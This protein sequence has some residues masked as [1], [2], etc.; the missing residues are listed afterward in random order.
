MFSVVAL[1]CGS[2]SLSAQ[3]P[4]DTLAVEVSPVDTLAVE[5]A[6]VDT[7]VIEVVPVDSLSNEVSP[8]DTLATES[9]S[10]DTPAV[11]TPQDDTLAVEAP[12]VDTLAVEVQPADTLAASEWTR[13]LTLKTNIAGW[14]LLMTNLAV[15]IDII[16]NL[17]FNLPVYYSGWD[18]GKNT[19]KFRTLTI[20]PEFRYYIPKAKGFYCGI[21][22]GLAHFNFALD[23]DWRYQNHKGE[24]LVYGGGLGI[25]W[26]FPFGKDTG[27]G[28]EIAVGGGMY[29]VNYDVFYNEFNGPYY[30]RDLHMNFIGVDQASISIKY[31]FDFKKAGKKEKEDNR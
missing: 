5:V 3:Q 2:L 29:H 30:K 21:H 18:Y 23:G 26:A 31:R 14:A 24:K 6:P 13:G 9:V 4:G 28:M 27:W 16:E 11:E 10:V 7:L 22:G 20:Q 19:L 8:V 17:S 12:Q 15:E 1:L 25:G